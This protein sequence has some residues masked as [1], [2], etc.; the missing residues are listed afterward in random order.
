M[1]LF[2]LLTAIAFH[3]THAQI[4]CDD[5]GGATCNVVTSV[6][7]S[8]LESVLFTYT[9]PGSTVVAD[10]FGT[11]DLVLKWN[12]EDGH[13]LIHS[14]DVY[15][16]DNTVPFDCSDVFIWNNDLTAPASAV[17]T[18]GTLND[19]SY[20]RFLMS[21]V[22]PR[23]DLLDPDEVYFLF[24]DLTDIGES[25]FIDRDYSLPVVAKEDTV[26][27]LYELEETIITTTDEYAIITLDIG[28]I[29]YTDTDFD[30]IGAC[31]NK[32]VLLATVSVGT[33]S[34]PIETADN[35]NGLYT[36]HLL[37]TQYDTCKDAVTTEDDNIV[38]TYDIVLPTDD[39]PCYYFIP[40]D[41]VQEIN[42]Q[43]DVS[44]IGGS[45]NV[46]DVAEV[47][48]Q[49][50][51][52]ELDRC[53]PTSLV[54]PHHKAIFHV[55]YTFSGDTMILDNNGKIPAL[56]N[57]ATNPFE[58][59]PVFTCV[60]HPSG[61]G[62][63][64]IYTFVSTECRPMYVTEADTC[65]T[66]RFND[67][68]LR[69]MGIIV[70]TA[71]TPVTHDFDAFN[72]AL[73]NTEFDIEN[74]Y[75]PANFTA[76]NV[77]DTYSPTIVVRNREFPDWETDP[78]FLAF[79]DPIIIQL[80]VDAGDLGASEVQIQ[81]VTVTI[82]DPSTDVVVAQQVFNRIVK[83]A[84][85]NFDWTS[86]YTDAHYCT[87]HN[88]DNTCEAFY[89]APRV[90]IDY[91]TLIQPSIADICQI[92]ITNSSTDYF[93]FDPELWFTDFQL[94]LLDINI[95]VVATIN[96]CDGSGRRALR[97]LDEAEVLTVSYISLELDDEAVRTIF[98]TT[99]DAPTMP[100]TTTAPTTTATTEESTSVNLSVILGATGGGLVLS[101]ACVWCMLLAGKRRRKR[102]YTELK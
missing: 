100:P 70:T 79:Y 82:K 6:N 33:C 42:V 89:L 64:C 90:N 31:N 102:K 88:T 101:T 99:T 61:T 23:A 37:K 39:A 91:G 74:C 63:E 3:D 77:T 85:N 52:Y 57:T 66:D 84:L 40:T 25:I 78:A 4:V 19:Q 54:I 59:N 76:V 62:Q 72:S 83:E 86:Y 95:D 16:L 73:E 21:E 51:G 67:N 56:D 10:A 69:E 27:Y 5:P 44:N 45:T 17:L 7:F 13:P 58:A 43:I 80:S 92:T 47:S 68:V 24:N 22:F 81:T 26:Y 65:V 35:V 8:N 12:P 75:D 55:N 1:F 30:G 34:L 18:R 41:S 9:N 48:M 87:H 53:D 14:F 50:V 36:F 32:E 96:L 71:G 11:Y 60:L 93:S 2:A 29:V 38:Y 28:D 46:T 97:Q 94:P 98:Q 49:V 20:C 15:P